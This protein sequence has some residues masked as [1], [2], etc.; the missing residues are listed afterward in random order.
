MLYFSY[1]R[2]KRPGL[3]APAILD[4]L[5]HVT[6][7]VVQFLFAI[8]NSRFAK[9]E[10]G[11]CVKLWNSTSVC[12]TSVIFANYCL[13]PDCEAHFCFSNLCECPNVRFTKSILFQLNSMQD[14]L[15]IRVIKWHTA[16]YQMYLNRIKLRH[17]T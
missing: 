17:K 12:C 14:C 6:K 13:A 2:Y 10:C 7:P 8:L 11:K 5:L 3:C 9:S 4:M 16:L 15:L 1:M